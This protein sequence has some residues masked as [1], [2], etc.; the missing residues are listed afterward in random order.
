MNELNLTPK[1]DRIHIAL[2][3]KTNV[4]KSSV[5]NALTSQDIALVSNVK[6]TTTDPVYKAM[7]LLPLGPVMIIDTA[8]LDDTSNL[9]NLRREKTFEVLD[10][11][12]I[13]ILVLDVESGV[14]DYDK[15]IYSLLS[16]KKIP[17]IGVLNKIDKKDFKIEDYASQFKIPIVPVSALKNTGIDDLKD[18][19]IRLA[20]ENEDKFKIVGDLLSPGDIAILVTPIDKA[21]PKGRLILPQQQTIRDILESDA[22]AIVTKEFELRETLESLNK[23]PKIVITD[24]Q[25][26]LKVAA[27]T[28]KDILMTSFSILMARH[29][30]DLIELARGAKA[31]ENL[32]DGDKVLIAEACTHHRQSDD[33]GKVKIPRWLRQKTG[34]K[35]E[36]DFS[37]GFSFPSN[38]EDY[39]LIVHCAG[40]MLNR[41]SMLHRID[42]SVKREV[43]IVNYG[44]LIA[45]VQGILPRALKPFPYADMI[46]NS[47]K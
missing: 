36:F 32:K 5:I 3:G 44:V 34:K 45:Y 22:I 38:I 37:S 46:F 43:P 15:T 25:V 42:V 8:G 20:P 26:F 39:A 1:G 6:G 13:A 30:G 28:P 31:I 47:N 18:E 27:D 11:T 7:E 17:L 41:R 9:G 23:K 21:A 16:E 4:G 14:T 24:S 19:L 35:L 40:C 10:K 33:I 29:K 2:F 12:D